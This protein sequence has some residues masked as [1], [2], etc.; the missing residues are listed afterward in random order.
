MARAGK[1]RARK[2]D[3][4]GLYALAGQKEPGTRMMVGL[5]MLGSC[6]GCCGVRRA[7]TWIR[8]D[9]YTLRFLYTRVYATIF[10]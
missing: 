8:F 7:E 4:I 3:I 5:D 10:S 9:L 2:C 6:C 1:P